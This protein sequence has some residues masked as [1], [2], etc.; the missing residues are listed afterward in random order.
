MSSFPTSTETIKTIMERQVN[1]FSKNGDYVSREYILDLMKKKY[2]L[3]PYEFG[4]N[5]EKTGPQKWETIYGTFRSAETGLIY[6]IGQRKSAAGTSKT[7]CDIKDLKVIESDFDGERYYYIDS[8]LQKAQLEKQTNPNFTPILTN[9]TIKIE[10]D[11]HTDIQAKI[12]EL[13]ILAGYKIHIPSSDRNKLLKNGMTINMKFEEHIV[14]DFTNKDKRTS[15]I[16]VLWIQGN[17][18]IRAFEVEINTGVV[19]GLSRMSSLDSS[20]KCHIVSYRED[21]EKKFKLLM[22][23]DYK[24]TKMNFTYLQSNNISKEVNNINNNIEAYDPQ[25]INKRYEKIMG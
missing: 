7:F 18:I 1:L 15:E 14:K 19:D 4:L 8:V 17:K 9:Q 25:E 16:D 3:D 5:R 13:G 24:N 21:Y 23:T 22:E 12:A 11:T 2:D 10:Q 6:C 20:V